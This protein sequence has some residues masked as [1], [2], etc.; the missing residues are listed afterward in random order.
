LGVGFIA[1][2]KLMRDKIQ[3]GNK[4]NYT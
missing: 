3:G 4:W 1:G 2:A